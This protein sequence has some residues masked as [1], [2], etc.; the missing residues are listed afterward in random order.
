MQETLSAKERQVLDYLSAT[1]KPVLKSHIGVAVGKKHPKSAA[2]WANP[3]LQSL[4]D[5]NLIETVQ[6]GNKTTYKSLTVTEQVLKQ[7][8]DEPLQALP[9]EKINQMVQ[10]EIDNHGE[11]DFEREIDI[12]EDLPGEFVKHENDGELFS[13]KSAIE[14]DLLPDNDI[15][16]TFPANIDG[17]DE[18]NKANSE[19][20]KP[21]NEDSFN[22]K[23][24]KREISRLIEK[25]IANKNQWDTKGRCIS[26]AISDWCR[27][28]GD[29]PEE[30][31]Q[32]VVR[33]LTKKYDP[34]PKTRKQRENM[35]SRI[36]NFEIRKLSREY[37][38]ELKKDNTVTESQYKRRLM[39]RIRD[40]MS[41]FY[42]DKSMRANLIKSYISTVAIE[43]ITGEPREILNDGRPFVKGQ[44][45][46][47]EN[48]NSE[49]MTGTIVRVFIDKVF[50]QRTIV[51]QP[52]GSN[53]NEMKVDRKIIEV[54]G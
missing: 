43:T 22:I 24:C 10:T 8:T 5:K 9:Q 36:D 34:R 47:Y 39:K 19:V 27:Q 29:I 53:K 35:L 44:R 11:E 46:K 54:I 4:L 7:R 14:N 25:N 26:N 41:P 23:K 48:K 28:N 12:D 31:F 18:F 17:S 16:K 38:E 1:E 33:P 20:Q 42:E 40:L 32:R 50:Y 49:V 37:L 2:T 13:G 15:R 3:I 21:K 52:D 51:V 30:Y 45:V 6:I